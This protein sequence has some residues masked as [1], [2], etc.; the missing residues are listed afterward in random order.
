[1]RNSSNDL[2]EY[3]AIKKGGKTGEMKGLISF[4]K[5][6]LAILNVIDKRD[7]RQ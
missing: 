2:L 6:L 5:T 7:N 4:L 3:V 1:M